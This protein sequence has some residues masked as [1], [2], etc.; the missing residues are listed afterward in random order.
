MSDTEFLGFIPIEEFEY[1]LLLVSI[2]GLAIGCGSESIK[3][4]VYNGIV[5]G[6]KIKI[7]VKGDNLEYIYNE[8][9]RCD[10]SLL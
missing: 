6:G 1:Y 10:E 3:D 5:E 7:T 2:L 8:Q 4:G 9:P